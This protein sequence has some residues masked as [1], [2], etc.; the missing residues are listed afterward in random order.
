MQLGQ[1][2]PWQ[3][4][5]DSR[6]LYSPRSVGIGI[7]PRR[8][9]MIS[10]KSGLTLSY[11]FPSSARIGPR[12]NST[13]SIAIFGTSAISTRRRAFANAGDVSPRTNFRKSSRASR[14]SIFIYTLRPRRPPFGFVP[15]CGTGVTSSIRPIRR[16]ARD[17]ARIAA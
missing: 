9:A 11:S 4:G 10:S 14:T 12:W 2:S 13:S 6:G 3:E 17:S 1:P 15:S 5:H 7:R 16:P 8:C